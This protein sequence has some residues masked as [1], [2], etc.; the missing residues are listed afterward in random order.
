M[1]ELPN[2][3][4]PSTVADWIELHLATSAK[5][6]SRLEIASVVEQASGDEPSEDFLNSIWIEL[7][8]RQAQYSNPLFKVI[9]KRI[10]SEDYSGSKE[11]YIVCLILSL[12][13][14]QEEFRDGPKL[15]ERLSAEV[16][17]RYLNGKVFIFGWPPIEGTPTAIAERI[18]SACECFHERF[19]ESP[20]ER[21]NDR[22]VDLVAWIPFIDSKSSQCV[23]LAQCASGHNWRE[24]TTRL[25]LSSW[26]QYI[27]WAC[28]PM[29]AFFVPCII[30]DNLWHDVSNEA[31][32][33][34][35]RIRIMNLIGDGIEDPQ[36]LAELREWREQ[37][38]QEIII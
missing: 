4:S 12:F 11:E 31:G 38:L 30:P 15:F 13:G 32:I 19:A 20:A 9:D 27:H 33:L 22:G 16:V 1:I 10:E 8:N 5:A 14:V 18:K 2:P 28:N 35:D 25:P 37:Q 6:I 23:I 7:I 17:K 21:Y 26:K 36:L 3:K 34:F 24:K 29:K